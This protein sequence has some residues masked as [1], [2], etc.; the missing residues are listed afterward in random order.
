M[1]QLFRHPVILCRFDE[2][3]V[4]VADGGKRRERRAHMVRRVRLCPLVLIERLDHV[5]VFGKR[6]A[7]SESEDHLAIGEM[8]NDL[9][10]APLSERRRLLG[11]VRADGFDYFAEFPGS[12]RNDLK[13]ILIAEE[14]RVGVQHAVS[15]AQ[16]DEWAV[17]P[18]GR[19]SGEA[20]ALAPNQRNAAPKGSRGDERDTRTQP[21]ATEPQSPRPRN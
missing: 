5:V 10:R 7:Q 3:Q 19:R 4:P 6:L 13:W 11:S 2:H 1:R 12:A 17:D 14:F 8:A 15:V 9:T 20:V 21:P 16:A 18:D